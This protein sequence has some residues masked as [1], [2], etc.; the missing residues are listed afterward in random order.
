MKFSFGKKPAEKPTEA[1]PKDKSISPKR[2]PE[3]FTQAAKEFEVF[4]VEEIK[5]SRK[6]AWII[7]IV[8]L[9]FTG[10]CIVGIVMSFALHREPSP[11]VLKVDNGTGNVEMLR[12]VKDQNDSYDD[13]VNKYWLAQYVRTCERYD[14]Y[15]ISIDYKSCELLSSPDVFKAYSTK[16]QS[17]QAPLNTLKDKGKIEIKIVSVVL[18]GKNNAQVRFTS[19]KLNAA[20]ENIDGAPLQ[21]WIATIAFGY[22]SVLMSEQQRLI[23][24]LGF[25][26]LTYRLDP[27]STTNR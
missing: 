1:K 3:T 20:G 25:K 21:R 24:P 27:E 5:K 9:V 6:M 4:K 19:Q 22:H 12:S 8:A 11:V 15:T 14:W 7:A 17:K 2:I 16:V 23:N 26:A 13:V 10:I 18:M